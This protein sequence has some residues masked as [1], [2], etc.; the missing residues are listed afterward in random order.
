MSSKVS[1]VFFF[2]YYSYACLL[3]FFLS[4]IDLKLSE[5]H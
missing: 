3:F 4:I 2:Y 1:G 5:G